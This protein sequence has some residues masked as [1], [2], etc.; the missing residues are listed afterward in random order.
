LSNGRSHIRIDRWEPVT[1]ASTSPGWQRRQTR[2]D[3]RTP[4]GDPRHR[5]AVGVDDALGRDV[6]D[7]VEVLVGGEV[8]QTLEPPPRRERGKEI[9]QQ[10]SVELRHLR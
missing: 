8:E 7:L 2:H 1:R 4:R 9:G 3:P 10:Q 5:R 6:A